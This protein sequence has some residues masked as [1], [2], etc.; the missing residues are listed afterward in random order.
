LDY[1]KQTSWPPLI[2]L[3]Q[4]IHTQRVLNLSNHLKTWQ[5]PLQLAL[6]T[7]LGFSLAGC[8]LTVVPGGSG[9]TTTT[10]I[11]NLSFSSD[12][13]DNQGK[14]YVCDN[15]TTGL[16]YTFRY[17]GQLDHW[18]SVLVGK[19]TG[20]RAGT[21]DL[22]LSSP[23]V[24]G[25]GDFVSVTY[26]VPPRTAPLSVPTGAVKPQSIIVSPAVLGY[27][28]LQIT[29]YDSFGNAGSVKLNQGIPVVSNC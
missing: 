5:R 4:G 3:T 7:A 19:Q 8:V 28:D 13:R 6:V 2:R 23:G 12:Y 10:T 24:N 17:S 14:S 26:N 27:T 11:S 21:A 15:A 1:I 9:G 25:S 29:F 16:T 18:T 20:Q 22:S